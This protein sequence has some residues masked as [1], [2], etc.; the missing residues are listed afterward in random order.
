MSHLGAFLAPRRTRVALLMAVLAGTLGVLAATLVPSATSAG[1]PYPDLRGTWT[2]GV[3]VGG[4]LASCETGPQYPGTINITDEDFIT[5]KVSI[6]G[7]G[8]IGQITNCSLFIDWPLSQGYKSDATLNISGD[9]NLMEGTFN[10]SYGRVAQP[11]FYRRTTPGPGGCPP[12]PTTTTTT[13]TTPTSTTPTTTTPAL[14]PTSV[15]V[16]CN[17]DVTTQVDTCTATVADATGAG[18]IP[19]GT[20]TF[21]AANGTHFLF[22]QTCTLSPVQNGVGLASCHGTLL[23]PNAVFPA[24]S[25][26]YS[27]DA[28]H[29][30]SSGAT[31]FLNAAPGTTAYVPTIDPFAPPTLDTGFKNPVSD[32]TVTTEASI[33]ENLT[34][35]AVC[36]VG[37]NNASTDDA[38][39]TA[40]VKH[41]VVAIVSAKLVKRHVR[42]GKVSMKLHFNAARLARA[43]PHNGKV[44]VVVI[45]TVKPP[46]G[47]PLSVYKRMTITLHLSK[48]LR[49]QARA[50]AH[51]ASAHAAQTGNPLEW[52]GESCGLLTI[53]IPRVG[54]PY[55][56]TVVWPA[57]LPCHNGTFVDMNFNDHETMG[58][59]GNAYTFDAT[60]PG[61]HVS[62]LL[63][64][65]VGTGTGGVSA[66]NGGAGCRADT[67]A[68][69]TQTQ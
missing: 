17:Y 33:T 56:G 22:G 67:P 53:R 13:S 11:A 32:S 58:R 66:T 36:S 25:A 48:R 20:V 8:Q 2:G 12:G 52:Q 55:T 31:Q 27:G 4:T 37:G 50:H 38:A 1:G 23:T 21:A 64:A 14:K 19:T 42:K 30:A 5:G 69:L 65:H 68:T 57:R 34:G 26:Q 43:F 59:Q 44:Q 16:V 39:T 6:S 54:P 40:A 63:G 41:K 28:T 18:T 29:A 46:K 61:Y 51:G 49:A 60:G 35:S 3:C 7:N 47:R 45:T 24:I 9:A 62:L 15:Q 10:D